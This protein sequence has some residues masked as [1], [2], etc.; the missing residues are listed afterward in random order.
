MLLDNSP[1][2]SHRPGLNLHKHPSSRR[3]LAAGSLQAP[4]CGWGADGSHAHPH[5]RAAGQGRDRAAGFGQ[6]H[7]LLPARG[8]DRVHAHFDFVALGGRLG[9]E[10]DVQ[11]AVVVAGGQH[12]VIAGSAR[13]TALA[14]GRTSWIYPAEAAA[15]D[16]AGAGW[17]WGRWLR[18]QA[19]KVSR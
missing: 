5:P 7:F 9:V 11:R 15:G 14:T 10:G 12:Q 18:T 3:V 16:A 6:R 13:A 8:R 2:T 4:C 17:R 19:W 1:G